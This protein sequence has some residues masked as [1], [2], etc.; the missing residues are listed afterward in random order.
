MLRASRIFPIKI[1]YN[2]DKSKKISKKE[3]DVY[4][5]LFSFYIPKE[6]SRLNERY[7]ELE[8]LEYEAIE[9]ERYLPK[10]FNRKDGIILFLEERTKVIEVGGEILEL[11]HFANG[12]IGLDLIVQQEYFNSYSKIVPIRFCVYRNIIKAY[13]KIIVKDINL[14]L[15]SQRQTEVNTNVLDY[16]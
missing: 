4:K 13:K 11:F 16:K 12:R 8:S 6:S 10:D 7:K 15:N 2:Y 9:R 14:S 5:R 3:R 1:P